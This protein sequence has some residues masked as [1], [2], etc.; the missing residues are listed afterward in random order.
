MSANKDQITQQI[1]LLSAVDVS[2]R[3]RAAQRLAEIGDS[4]AYY[5]LHYRKL[6]EQ[7]ATT[8]EVL[9]AA[10][11]RLET[12]LAQLPQETLIHS[13][14]AIVQPVLDLER[15]DPAERAA[16]LSV[17]AFVEK[18]RARKPVSSPLPVREP[19]APA[20]PP[21]FPTEISALI[22]A[23]RSPNEDWA[24]RAAN[25]IFVRDVEAT[26]P[27]RA[28]F[29]RADP[30]HR[31]RIAGVLASI[32]D[33]ESLPILWPAWRDGLDSREKVSLKTALLRL[34]AQLRSRYDKVTL[35]DQLILLTESRDTLPALAEFVAQAL[36]QRAQTAPTPELRAALPLLKGNWLHPAPLAFEKARRA[37]E[38]VTVNSTNLP[39]A[40]TAPDTAA[41][42]LPVP[43]ET[44]S[45]V[46]SRNL[47]RADEAAR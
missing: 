18:L 27:L 42:N 34:G 5:A 15:P 25:A 23:L 39:I 10:I 30:L 44:K 11:H 35:K 2:A 9:R 21:S 41:D 6:F 32:G 33:T 16:A 40:A 29:S 47:P 13:M 31:G 36:E 43:A 24:R 28:A 3:R 17:L 1:P 26:V 8:R 38:A 12:R 20:P 22:E 19:A 4:E 7:D 45:Q 14:Q 46:S 37:I